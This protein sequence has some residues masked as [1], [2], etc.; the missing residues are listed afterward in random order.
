VTHRPVAGLLVGTAVTAVLQSS[1][2]TTVMLVSLVGAGLLSL[3]HA[4][5][6]ILGADIGTTLTVQL[7][8]FRVT[9]YGILLVGL[10]WRQ[11]MVCAAPSTVTWARRSW[12]W[13]SSSCP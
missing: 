11:C 7:I 3:Q 12:A 13:A 5:G 9:D 1:S 2:A 4:I 6:I 8:A 10:A